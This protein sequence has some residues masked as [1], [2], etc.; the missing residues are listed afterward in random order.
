MLILHLPT[1]ADWDAAQTTG[2]QTGNTLSTEGLIHCATP[3][4]LMH[5]LTK[6]FPKI[7]DHV[8]AELESDKVTSEIRWEGA[9][10]VFPRGFPHIYGPLNLSAVT[11]HKNIW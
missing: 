3:D 4:Q 1:R 6:H 2:L 9:S 7:V 11:R 10:P 8:I 5:V